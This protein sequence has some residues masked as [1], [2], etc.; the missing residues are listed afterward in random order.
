MRTM[1]MMRMVG[2]GMAARLVVMDV[3]VIMAM[4]MGLIA[5][6]TGQVGTAF[7]IERRLDRRHPGSEPL[8]HRLE[9]RI[10]PQADA[11][12]QHL[13]RHVPVAQRPGDA[14]EAGGIGGPDLAKRLGLGHHFDEIAT[15][16]HERVA[17]AQA[18]RLG[19]I[20][21]ERRPLDADQRTPAGTAPLVVEDH[22]I[23]D[24]PMIDQVDRQ[25]SR[26]VLHGSC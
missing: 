17:A 1:P 13:D 12:R 26:G 9:R 23:D 4:L 24:P 14:G 19:K 18:H 10:R 2:I 3:I 11:V 15:I 7:R 20:D 25:N 8:E 16:E 22:G 6:L 21:D 5:G